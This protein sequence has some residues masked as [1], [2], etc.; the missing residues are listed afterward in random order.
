MSLFCSS[1]CKSLLPILLTLYNYRKTRL[2]EF[3]IIAFD[4]CYVNDN[5]RLI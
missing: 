1:L 2:I 5:L 3:F 4:L